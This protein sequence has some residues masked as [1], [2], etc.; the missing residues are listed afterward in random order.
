M[1]R[2]AV[3]LIVVMKACSPVVPEE[4]SVAIDGDTAAEGQK[5]Q[6]D[7]DTST[8][9]GK[10]VPTLS[11]VSTAPQ[12]FSATGPS[13]LKG[14][15]A[16]PFHI[17]KTTTPADLPWEIADHYEV[18]DLPVL[19]VS[20]KN[21]WEYGESTKPDLQI[22]SVA[23]WA[24]ECFFIQQKGQN[25]PGRLSMVTSYIPD[26]MYRQ[27]NP[28]TCTRVQTARKEVATHFVNTYGDV[29]ATY[30]PVEGFFNNDCSALKINDESQVWRLRRNGMQVEVKSVFHYR[31]LQWQIQVDYSIDAYNQLVDDLQKAQNEQR[32]KA[33]ETIFSAQTWPSLP[34]GH[35]IDLSPDNM[36]WRVANTYELE[37]DGAKLVSLSIGS[38]D[39]DINVL[40]LPR[41]RPHG[42]VFVWDQ[43][44]WKLAR[45]AMLA[46]KLPTRGVMD[47][48]IV[49]EYQQ[50]LTEA[51]A[52][53]L[54]TPNATVVASSTFGSTDCQ[55]LRFG[56]VPSR[57]TLT[58]DGIEISV[59]FERVKNTITDQLII[60]YSVVALRKLLPKKLQHHPW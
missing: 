12:S 7:T 41:F 20:L 40:G 1:I 23:L 38:N 3:V 55:T 58:R 2:L 42:V 45:Y 36:P 37:S 21:K 59:I 5:K 28:M 18:D 19:K 10:P 57:W 14:E 16:F 54:Q 53:Q 43:G 15:L 25:Y 60:E 39:D 31:T 30:P 47:C 27:P 33:L 8:S 17:S 11:P 32:G 26:K 48:S 46:K 51:I 6:P 56:D 24:D 49:A 29:A 13:T 52:G 34:F 22:D 44:K 50:V 35:S 9:K 4:T